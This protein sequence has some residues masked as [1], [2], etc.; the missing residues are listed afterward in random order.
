MTRIIA[1]ELAGTRIHGNRLGLATTRLAQQA[2][3][4]LV[5]GVETLARGAAVAVVLIAVVV[6]VIVAV[7]VVLAI[8]LVVTL[9]AAQV[10]LIFN[11]V[12][13]AHGC[14]L[15]R[16]SAGAPII[17][18]HFR[19]LFYCKLR[20]K[21]YP[22]QANERRAFLKGRLKVLAHPTGK[23]GQPQIGMGRFQLIPQLA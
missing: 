12:K 13:E 11:L 4:R 22:A 10:H 23:L 9:L 20:A 16:F 2:I 18:A 17:S 21:Y 1:N 7:V 6:A 5:L 19:A 3:A 14:V 8:T 15:S